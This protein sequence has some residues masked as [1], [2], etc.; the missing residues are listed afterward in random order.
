MSKSKKGSLILNSAESLLL[1]FSQF[2]VNLCEFRMTIQRRVHSTHR[3]KSHFDAIFT[4]G[5]RINWAD[6][7]ARIE[8]EVTC[9]NSL[10][11]F[12]ASAWR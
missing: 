4:A 2:R 6:I 12:C 1:P 3:W 11:E 9:R 5:F 7:L 10:F 8:V